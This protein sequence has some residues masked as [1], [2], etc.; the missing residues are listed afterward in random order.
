M[1]YEKEIPLMDQ[2]RCQVEWDKLQPGRMRFI[3]SNYQFA[4]SGV[5]YNQLTEKKTYI[6]S[7]QARF[8]LRNLMLYFPDYL[9]H[10][11]AIDV[12]YPDPDSSPLCARQCYTHVI[13][14]LKDSIEFLG[15]RIVLKRKLGYKLEI[16]QPAARP[17]PP[18]S[19]PL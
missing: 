5:L 16:H 14:D 13:G 3:L 1:E 18:A 19:S 6:Q 7:G 8:I 15:L 4:A 10:E 9:P 12:M 17:Q 2:P 11:S